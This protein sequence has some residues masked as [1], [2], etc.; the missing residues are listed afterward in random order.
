MNRAAALAALALVVSFHGAGDGLMNNIG[1]P[2][3][4]VIL[5]VV[6]PLVWL[7]LRALWRTGSK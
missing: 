5:V 4:L 7:V 1:L 3:L 6:V 2:G